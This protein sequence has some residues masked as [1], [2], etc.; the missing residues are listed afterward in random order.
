MA[1]S[2]L[3]L[4]CRINCISRQIRKGVLKHITKNLPRDK[5]PSDLSH[6]MSFR[7][8]KPKLTHSFC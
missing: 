8:C 2:Y 7:R 6:R 4:A 3:I 1:M 5:T